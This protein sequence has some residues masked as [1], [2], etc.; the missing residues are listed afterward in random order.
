MVPVL[1]RWEI[2][3]K[4]VVVDVEERSV[5]LRVG[6]EMFVKGGKEGVRNEVVWW[7]DMEEKEGEWK[8]GRSVEILDFGA[9][10]RIREIVGGRGG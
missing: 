9:A 5:V 2:V 1:E 8:V 4:G 10:A 6:Y 3:V 7:L